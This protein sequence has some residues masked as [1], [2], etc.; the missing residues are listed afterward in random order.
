MS[1]KV[2]SICLIFRLAGAGLL[3]WLPVQAQPD[4]SS[5]DQLFKRDQKSLG[6]N[7]VAAI[8]K[9]GKVVYLRQIEKEQGDFSAKTQA[10]L[11]ACGNW[12]TA[13]LV[14]SFVEQGKLSLD[15][16]VSKYLP[17]FSTYMKGYITIRNC[18]TNTTGIQVDVGMKKA[19]EKSKF[20]SLEDQ[21]NSFASNHE[22]QTNPGTEFFYSNIGPNIAGRILEIVGKKGFDRLMQERITRPLKMRGTSFYND[23]GGAIDPSAGGKSTVNDYLNFLSMLLNKGIF[24]GK[25][26]LSEQSVAELE[27]LQFA[28]IPVKYVPKPAIGWQYTLGA[29]VQELDSKGDPSVITVQDFAGS[30]AYFDK[31]RNYAAVL[32][33]KNSLSEPPKDLYK[34]FKQA[35]DAQMPA[36]CQ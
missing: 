34:R 11:E 17:I 35:A 8:W 7:V 28:D 3:F 20:E 13:A 21:V 27:K 19:F 23:E 24:E 36:S 5:L 18:L 32:F 1:L 26:I 10:P 22:I 25:R 15:D 2:G 9:D 30:F 16:K 6:N 12:L 14:M 29:W 4:F 33:T 31:C